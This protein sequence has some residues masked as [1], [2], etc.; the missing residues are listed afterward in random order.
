MHPK[1]ELQ[2]G[3]GVI[4][5]HAPLV[6]LLAW[7]FS[8]EHLVPRGAPG[9]RL[10]LV[11][12]SSPPEPSSGATPLDSQRPELGTCLLEGERLVAHI[13]PDPYAAEAALRAA[14]GTCLL[15]QGGLL[16]HAAAVA[17]N[18]EALVILG[19]SGAGKSTL[20]RAAV[21]AG[22]ELLSDE[23]VGLHPSGRV[24]GTPFRSD[25]DMVPTLAEARLARLCRVAKG[26]HEALEPLSA[27]EA[28]RTLLQQAYRPL[29][30]TVSLPEL[31][32]RAAAWAE[33]RGLYR[34]TCRKHPEAG[35]FA[36]SVVA[37]P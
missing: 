5:L 15:R 13:P 32:A 22:G 37:A 29:P 14:M 25:P 24:Y 2:A 31:A 28:V 35:T 23:T 8:W 34:L 3:E 30:G 33:R 26:P 11:L 12:A 36:R 10:E 21:A 16:L 7:R 6:P 27:S 17:F 9:P 19:H 4:L 1:A 20:A 18:G